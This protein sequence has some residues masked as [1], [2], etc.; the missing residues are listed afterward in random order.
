M[1][2]ETRFA[3]IIAFC[4]CLG[5]S[6]AGYISYRLEMRQA[7]EEINQQ[8]AMLLETAL[9]IRAYTVSDVAPAVRRLP[10]SEFHQA[11]VPSFA[12]QT[13]MRLIEAK[14]P[15]FKYRE[16]ALNPTNVHDRATDWEVGL[17]RQFQNDP[18]LKELSG[19]T[20]SGEASRFF[21]ARPIR[22]AS[23]AC[24]QCHSTP[25]VAPRAMVA[26]YGPAQGFGW[27]M[28][29]PVGVQLVE[30][31]TAPSRAQAISSVLVTIGSLSCVFVLSA[32]IFLMLLRRYVTH[33]LDLLTRA[34]HASSLSKATHEVEAAPIGGQFGELQQ[35]IF[36]LKSSVDHALRLFEQ[37][38]TSS[39]E[40]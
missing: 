19:Q 34:A 36:R 7:Q 8:A 15:G 40:E 11:Q 14:F 23:A 18:G 29:E 12:A 37:R 38:H 28:E 3:W 16:S 26:K 35:A 39:R 2:I 13:T 30:I 4:F 5:V 27:K 6:V 20:G 32:A 33:P 25:E 24:L 21:L 17:L 22:M 9:A 1:R 10:E 31:P